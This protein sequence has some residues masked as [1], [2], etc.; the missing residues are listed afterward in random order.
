LND[1]VNELKCL[2]FNV[3]VRKVVPTLTRNERWDLPLNG[4]C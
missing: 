3:S 2:D 4:R 1:I